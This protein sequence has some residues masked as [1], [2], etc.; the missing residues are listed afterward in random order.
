MAVR[1]NEITINEHVHMLMKRLDELKRESAS[2][3]LRKEEMLNYE[4]PKLEAL[5]TKLIGELLYEEYRLK[6]ELSKISLT[7][8]LLQSY[9]N[10]N[11]SIDIEAV[12]S[13]VE[14]A[15]EEYSR[16][17]ENHIES[18]KQANDYFASSFMSDNDA[19]EL[20][21]SYRLI[22]KKLHP[23]INPDATEEQKDLF[24][25]ATKAYKSSDL[26]TIRSIVLMLE[27]DVYKELP[28]E[29]LESQ[30]E[31]V[32]YTIK[33]LKDLIDTMKSIFPFTIKD[34]IKDKKW[35]KSEQER[36]NLSIESLKNSLK[37]KQQYAAVLKLWRPES[38][39]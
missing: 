30:I 11:A 14:N 25:K 6:T 23:D 10:R 31:K 16:I 8:D 33:S 37:E 13:E 9:I 38:L 2:L 12:E 24:V 28:E 19:K 34:K 27:T 3:F 29:T 1:N 22:V 39:S 18:V 32:E 35:V 7:I 26:A 4:L 36:L 15:F 21:S 5:Y 20:S 17:I